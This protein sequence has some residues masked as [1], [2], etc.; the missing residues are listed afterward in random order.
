MLRSISKVA[1]TAAA[2]AVASV[3]SPAVA[4]VDPTAA[5][6]H[7]DA[8]R[9]SKPSPSIFDDEYDF[10][11][12]DTPVI[13]ADHL[14]PFGGVPSQEEADAAAREL[15]ATF[16]QTES[17]MITSP[18]SPGPSIN[19]APCA[20]VGSVSMTTATQRSFDVQELTTTT[21]NQLVS[22]SAEHSHALSLL[23]PGGSHVVARCIDLMQTDPD[24]QAAVVSLAK[25][26]AIWDAF[27]KNEKVQELMRA[28]P[29]TVS[30]N[31]AFDIGYE[32]YEEISSSSIPTQSQRVNPFL[33]AFNCIRN[34]VWEMMDTM[35]DLVNGVFGFV[36]RKIFGDKDSDPTDL[37]VKACMVLTILVLALVVFKRNPTPFA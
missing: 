32:G 5:A 13:V 33:V 20:E 16:V 24:V 4:H 28:R 9:L 12:E 31:R 1:G 34:V 21:S 22:S 8:S 14:T 37:P 26:P 36:D 15:K 2:T 30:H 6:R 17:P 27:V 23:A 3:S 25:D 29:M 18:R 7:R 11:Q 10:C 19:D 35:V